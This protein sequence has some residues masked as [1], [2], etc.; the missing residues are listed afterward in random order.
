MYLMAIFL[1]AIIS[2]F[3]QIDLVLFTTMGFFS[4]PKVPQLQSNLFIYIVDNKWGIFF[5]SSFEGAATFVKS[6]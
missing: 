1:N 6:N 5:H 4:F 3:G 2:F